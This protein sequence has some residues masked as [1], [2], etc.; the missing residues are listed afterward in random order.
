SNCQPICGDGFVRGVETCDD[1]NTTSGDGCS[2]NFCRQEPGWSC[3]G[4]PSACTRTCGN[5]RLDPQEE[6]DDGNR[7]AGD[8]CGT[9]CRGEVGYACGGE[10]SV[11][12][13]TCGNRALDAGETCDDG[14]RTNGDGCSASCRNDPGWYCPGPGLACN[15]FEIFIDGPPHGTF[16]TAPT[17]TVTGHY[18]VLPPG[19]AALTV[20][21]MPAGSV[22][23]ATR[24]FAHSFPLSAPA[25]LNAVEVTLTNTANGDAVNDR[26]V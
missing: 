1:H 26:I 11:C 22:D 19:L 2:G 13:P 7:N 8:G 3:L 15:R 20:N 4:Q 14:N 10:P 18:T 6:C 5:G 25:I 17:T 16:T 23:P 24:T 9:S 12:V 21:G